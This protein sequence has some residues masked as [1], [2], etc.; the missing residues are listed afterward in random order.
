MKATEPVLALIASV[1]VKNAPAGI[2]KA[3]QHLATIAERA[4]S[5]HLSVDANLL[6][7]V[8]QDL[9]SG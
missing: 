2:V 9:L 1:V 8:R 5:S 7:K 3:S 6:Q 4:I